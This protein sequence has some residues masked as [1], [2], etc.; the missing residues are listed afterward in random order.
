MLTFPE[1]VTVVEVGPRDG[2]QSLER[3]IESERKVAMIDRLSDAGFPVIEVT[4]F[5]HPRVVPMLRDAEEV[6]ARIKRRPGTVYRALVPNKR[7]ALR[8]VNTNIDEILGLMT[9]SASYLAKNQ[10]MSIDNAIAD[11]GQCFRVADDAGR[12]FIMALGMS[13]FCP[14]E[15]VIPPERTLDCVGRLRNAGI[16]RFYLAAS[17]GLEEP[18]QVSTL[19]RQAQDRF[20]DCEFSFHL[21]EKMGLAPANLLAALDAGVTTVEGSICGIGGGIAFPGD[22]GTVGNLPTEDIVNFLNTMGI[23]TGLETDAVLA[24][25]RDVA[26]L[27][28][29]PLASRLG[30]IGTRADVARKGRENPAAH[31]A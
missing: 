4:S 14:Y 29:I 3:W 13:M 15:G 9:I 17:T 10:N 21:H 18:R 20:P 1:R 24:A 27:A 5:A 25:A 30:A 6:V 28:D 12:A 11:G 23:E 7:G 19:F 16:T 26:A 22:M 8:A 31:P 2:L